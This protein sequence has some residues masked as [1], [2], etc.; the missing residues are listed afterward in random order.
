MVESSLLII[1]NQYLFGLKI[2]S[3]RTELILYKVI[4]IIVNAKIA[5]HTMADSGDFASDSIIGE[6]LV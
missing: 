1:N 6:K 5:K 2:G 4:I 3:V